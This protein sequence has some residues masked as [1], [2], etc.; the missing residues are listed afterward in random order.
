MPGWVLSSSPEGSD[1]QK[2][3]GKYAKI[4]SSRKTTEIL[5]TRGE[6]AAVSGDILVIFAYP[7]G[8]YL[9][10][11]ESTT[12][13]VFPRGFPAY[14]V[15]SRWYSTSDSRFSPESELFGDRAVRRSAAAAVRGKTALHVGGLLPISGLI[16]R[17]CLSIVSRIH[18]ARGTAA[19]RKP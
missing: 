15:E 4:W 1:A 3:E 9:V 12:P 19:L 17:L 18:F 7:R 2:Y 6:C 8:W 10:I 13:V 11:V 5:R 16:A 14:S